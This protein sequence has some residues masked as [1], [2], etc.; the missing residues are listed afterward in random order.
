MAKP[1]G[2]I[3]YKREEVPHRP[4]VERTRDF[5]EVDLPLPAE[6]LLKQAARCMDC[7][8]PFCHG[9]GC[10]VQNLIP[11]FNDLVYHGKWEQACRV[12]HSTNNFP[13]VTGRICPAPCES[14]CTLNIDQVPVNIK[15]IEL[16]IVERG[17][18]EGWI[19]PQPPEHKTGKHVAIIGSGPAGLAAAQQLA[20]MGH[21]VIVFEKDSRIGG[22]LRYGIPDFK[23]DKKVLDRRLEQMRAEGVEFQTSV[24][25]GEDLSPKYLRQ[26]FDAILLTMGAGEPRDLTIEGRELRNVHF[27]LEFL[28]QQN[29]VNAG[30][31]IP[32]AE[33]ILAKDKVVAVIGGG[34]TGSDCIGTAIRQGAKQVYQFEILPKPPERTNPE[35]PW[36]QWPRVLRT[37][38]SQEEG[39]TRRW[40]VQTKKLL[41][42]GDTVSTL[43]GAEVRWEKGP[44]GGW[45]MQEVP[46]SEFRL[47][48]DLVLLAMG[49]THVRHNGLVDQ[50]EL[51]LDPRGNVII[52][53]DYHTSVP[54]VF[55]A[56]DTERGAS[57]VVHAI[58]AGRKAAAGID[59]WLKKQETQS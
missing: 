10:P 16:Q 12:L 48:V 21:H 9:A 30:D 49:F 39:C 18:A 3:E 51:Q 23:L 57:L 32:L 4:V 25:I 17:W 5:F 43:E 19:R 36:P 11:E 35:T 8:I 37:S 14:A 28:T 55:A 59:E 27:A 50:L 15:Q 2:F 56:G 13:E 41:G 40:C 31:A 52:G 20:R 46:G 7:G 42:R 24:T 6:V 34:D 38:S 26:R 47:D 45:K 54:G 33:H 58:A 29:R 53:A 44:D 1:T 22:L